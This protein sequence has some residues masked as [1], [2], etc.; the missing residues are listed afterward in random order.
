MNVPSR[1]IEEAGVLTKKVLDDDEEKF[2]VNVASAVDA[3][4]NANPPESIQK[5]VLFGYMYLL[6]QFIDKSVQKKYK[7]L[8]GNNYSLYPFGI[9]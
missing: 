1:F 7:K 9:S 8:I 5:F 3:E 6:S 2:I 4:L